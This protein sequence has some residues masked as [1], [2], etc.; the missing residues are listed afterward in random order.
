MTADVC[1]PSFPS[2]QQCTLLMRMPT[3]NRHRLFPVPLLRDQPPHGR[4]VQAAEQG[5]ATLVERCAAV[6]REAAAVAARCAELREQ[7]GQLA[8]ASAVAGVA[9]TKVFRPRRVLLSASHANNTECAGI[10]ST[11][12][13]TLIGRPFF[14]TNM[15]H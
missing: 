13:S 2:V 8:A 15:H 5:L 9:K 7:H 10:G 12:A 3:P 11:F 6:E 4:L 14:R 1:Q